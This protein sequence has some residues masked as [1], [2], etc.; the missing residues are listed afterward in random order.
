[1]SVKDKHMNPTIGILGGGQLGKMLYLAGANLDM[2]IDMM[3]SMSDGPA[4]KVC[5]SY[6]IGDFMDYD[7]V[8]RFGA[9]KDIITI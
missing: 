2:T 6:H 3:D 8:I 1:M 5:K 7:H 9:D 4:S